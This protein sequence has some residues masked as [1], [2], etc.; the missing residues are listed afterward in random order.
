V[1]ANVGGGT[2]SGGGI[3]TH[4]QEVVSGSRLKA[5]HLTGDDGSRMSSVN[6]FYDTQLQLYC[7]VSYPPGL[8][9]PLVW[10]LPAERCFPLFLLS[11]RTNCF[12]DTVCQ[13]RCPPFV[14]SSNGFSFTID[15]ALYGHLLPIYYDGG[16]GSRYAV[17]GDGGWALV[18]GLTTQETPEYYLQPDAG[19]RFN[20]NVSSGT[21]AA[22]VTPVPITTFVAF[23]PNRD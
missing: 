13:T 10:P 2:G 16:V 7:S 23:T 21:V 11:E 9:S 8:S 5:I 12:T 17:L 20:T 1:G 18:S 15:A 19:C 4:Q 22:T 14:T 3:G 6:A